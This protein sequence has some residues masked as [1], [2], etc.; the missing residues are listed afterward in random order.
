[1]GITCA[2]MLQITNERAP[3]FYLLPVYVCWGVSGLML[4]AVI[5]IPESPWAYARQ[6]K[7]EKALKSMRR[8]YG[9]IPDF[10]YE[11]EYSIIEHTLNLE[12]HALAD[13]KATYWKDL[14]VGVNKWRTGTIVLYAFSIHWGG[15]P[16]VSTFGTCT[17]PISCPQT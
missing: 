3:D 16:L 8:L 12:N 9:N 4:V 10:N 11:E 5:I 7:K 13:Q 6:G 15:M 1:M 2:V 14:F 17:W